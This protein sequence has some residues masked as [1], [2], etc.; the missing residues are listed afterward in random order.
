M[1]FEK[2][3]N[4]ITQG[5][6]DG[7][8]SCIEYLT[9]KASHEMVYAFVIYCTSGCTS[10]GVSASTRESLERKIKACDGVSENYITVN[11]PEWEYVNINYE[12]FQSTDELIDELYDDFYD[13]DIDDIEIENFFADVFIDVIKKIKDEGRFSTMLFEDDLLLGLQF[14]D[15]SLKGIEMATRVSEKVNTQ[16]WHKVFVETFA[17]IKKFAS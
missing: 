2:Y 7:C 9:N 16:K 15:P 4:N 8:L 11:S 10:V 5:I 14:C 3:R 1:N 12:A 17:E 13:E 6:Y